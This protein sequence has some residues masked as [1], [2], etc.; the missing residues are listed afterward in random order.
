MKKEKNFPGPRSRRLLRSQRGGPVPSSHPLLSRCLRSHLPDTPRRVQLSS[1]QSF[2]PSN[3]LELPRPQAGLL[4]PSPQK[5]GLGDRGKNLGL[6]F[7]SRP[8]TPCQ[9]AAGVQIGPRLVPGW[10]YGACGPGRLR[11]PG[12]RVGFNG[13]RCAVLGQPR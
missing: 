4:S 6:R 2:P 7:C 10:V 12:A 1:R 13:G 8:P 11:R 9:N 5:V 3:P